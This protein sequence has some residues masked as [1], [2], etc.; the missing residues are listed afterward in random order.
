MISAKLNQT[1]SL[2][3]YGN[4]HE[5]NFKLIDITEIKK[6]VETFINDFVRTA[7][8]KNVVDP[9]KLTG[10]LDKM[11]GNREERSL[12]KKIF[13]HPFARKK[14]IELYL[15]NLGQPD[16]AQI[17]TSRFWSGLKKIITKMSSLSGALKKPHRLPVNLAKAK[18]IKPAIRTANM[19]L[20]VV[21]N[22]IAVYAENF[23]DAKSFAH[24]GVRELKALVLDEGF[25]A[26]LKINQG[27]RKEFAEACGLARKFFNDYYN[28]VCTRNNRGARFA[29][30]KAASDAMTKSFAELSRKLKN[31]QNLLGF[32]KDDIAGA[33][34]A[35]K[36]E[37]FIKG[38][39]FKIKPPKAGGKIRRARGIYPRTNFTIKGAQIGKK[40]MTLLEE[41]FET[42]FKFVKKIPYKLF[43]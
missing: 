36:L 12:I 9:N 26:F 23:Q 7:L 25:N 16:C 19:L 15:Q 33:S 35:H 30:K 21:L 24:A 4:I 22:N 2:E 5:F 17:I 27:A 32:L 39:N 18:K 10:I 11:C 20:E 34:A 42:F 31:S 3:Q 41:Y 8:N 14:L 37:S 28:W 38:R 40:T 13:T 6:E 1:K 43:K 29:E